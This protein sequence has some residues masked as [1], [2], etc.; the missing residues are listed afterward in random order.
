MQFDEF[1]T[2]LTNIS[3]EFNNAVLTPYTLEDIR[4]SL[5]QLLCKYS[6]VFSISGIHNIEV[7]KIWY[8]DNSQYNLAEFIYVLY[9]KNNDEQRTKLK[10]FFEQ[11]VTIAKFRTYNISA[12]LK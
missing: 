3:N 4:Y 5:E 1:N 12:I 9:S 2:E 6:G 7:A 10:Y 8:N 11:N